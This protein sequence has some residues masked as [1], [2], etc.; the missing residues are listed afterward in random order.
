MGIVPHDAE[1]VSVRELTDLLLSTPSFEEYTQA[2]ATHA[3]DRIIPGA[4]TGLRRVMDGEPRTIASRPSIKESARRCPADP[5]RRRSRRRSAGPVL[6]DPMQFEPS[7]IQAGQNFADQTVS[8][9]QFAIRLTHEVE[10]TDQINEAMAS[11]G[12]AT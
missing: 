11:R 1:P 8:A 9:L 6:H 3:A 4:A 12:T 10:L 7:Q 5:R 2:L